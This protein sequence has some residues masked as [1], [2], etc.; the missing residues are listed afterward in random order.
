M[1]SIQ[2][3]NL[4]DQF[5]VLTS[6][7][8]LSS[9]D[10]YLTDSA[11]VAASRGSIDAYL[12][13]LDAASAKELQAA[14]NTMLPV[15]S[16]QLAVT[17]QALKATGLILSDT[18]NYAKGF[19][20]DIAALSATN[21]NTL[22]NK[23]NTVGSVTS[24]PASFQ[25]DNFELM[26]QYNFKA[27]LSKFYAKYSAHLQDRRERLSTALQTLTDVYNNLTLI[28]SAIQARL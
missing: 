20:D 19:K 4:V 15:V 22:T 1:A 21:I 25:T 26:K 3:P 5:R 10:Q 28:Q 7:M 2:P 16:T 9:S 17:A 13:N 24:V 18:M 27:S 11:L 23:S 8:T 14:I 6:A 12:S